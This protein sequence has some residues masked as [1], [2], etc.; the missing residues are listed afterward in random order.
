MVSR[1]ETAGSSTSGLLP[2]SPGQLVLPDVH[3][4]RKSASMLEILPQEIDVEEEMRVYED[5]CDVSRSYFLYP[6]SPRRTIDHV[7]C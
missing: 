4:L 1:N 5:M 7:L 3:T 6:P 2:Q